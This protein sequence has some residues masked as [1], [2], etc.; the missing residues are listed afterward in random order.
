MSSRDAKDLELD[1]RRVLVSLTLVNLHKVIDLKLPFRHILKF[2][3]RD[4]A[5]KALKMAREWKPDGC[6]LYF[7]PICETRDKKWNMY[8]TNTKLQTFTVLT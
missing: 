1:P 4:D 5:E 8:I 6:T 3:S 7:R 2:D